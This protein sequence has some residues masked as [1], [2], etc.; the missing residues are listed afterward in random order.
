[1]ILNRLSDKDLLSV[2]QAYKYEPDDKYWKQRMIHVFGIE[3]M[4]W[5][6]YKTNLN[7]L[8]WEKYYN[9]VVRKIRNGFY[10]QNK[11]RILSLIGE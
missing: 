5:Q 8:T 4:S 11:Q 6:I 1:M 3:S 9:F 7:I 2:C 10:F